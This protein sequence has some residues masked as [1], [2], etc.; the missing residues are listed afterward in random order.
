MAI[1]SGGSLESREPTITRHAR[2]DLDL[3]QLNVLDTLLREQNLSRAAEVLNMS[4][5]ALSKTLARSREHFDDQLFVRVSFQM[6]PT[7]KSLGLAVQIK[8]ILEQISTLETAHSFSPETSSRHFK[9][10]GPDIAVI[11]LLPP[12]LKQMRRQAPDVRLSAVE[13]D[14]KHLHEWLESGTVDL[15]A[16]DYP[17]L[18]RGIKRQRLL[19]THQV[20]LVRKGHPRF[21][22]LPSLNVFVEEQH[23][24]VSTFDMLHYARPAEEALELAIPKK[25][26]AARVPGFASAAL[27]AK[28]SDAIVTLPKPIAMIMARE[29]DLDAFKTPHLSGREYAPDRYWARQ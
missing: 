18:V 23:V 7:A 11:V 21:S 5:P 1:I 12:I 25:H 14:G 26:V 3:F 8:P 16:G 27:L 15:A 19:G 13:L 6:K 29:L 28:Y 4:Q 9:F 20:S 2:N 22:D 17:F 10:A 24:L